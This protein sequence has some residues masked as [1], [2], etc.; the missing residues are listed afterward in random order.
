M[1]G[2][3]FGRALAD[4]VL[5]AG[6]VPRVYD[7]FCTPPAALAAGSSRALV[8]SSDVVVLAVP[9]A[10]VAT[11]LAE[12]RPHL[13]HPT[14]VMDVASVKLG[15]EAALRAALGRD[16]RWVATHPL[17]GPSSL[18]R[19][20]RP[21]RAVVCP[22]PDHPEAVR[23]AR[24]LYERLGCEVVET[25]ADAHDRIM[26]RT[27]ALAFFVAKAMV[28]VEGGEPVP[29]SPPSFR[30]MAR[31]I[32]TVRSDA[33]HL[34]FAIQHENAHAAAERRRFI[35]ALEAIDHELGHTDV[36]APEH[37]ESRLA[38]PDLEA[39]APELRHI[40]ELIAE[41]DRELV[42]LVAR[43]VRLSRRAASAGLADRETDDRER[44]SADR[45]AWATARGLDPGVI[46][47]I[48]ESIAR[49]V[50]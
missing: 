11:A 29:F 46:S 37:V 23:R 1:G 26:A 25:D 24:D 47:E 28:E 38:I 50:D 9:V 15:P 3:R 5:E 16:I 19:G 7:P 42:E 6:H 27:H 2:G 35:D 36:A 31:T 17:F 45:E 33:G 13:R 22:N 18:A 34:F 14:W 43:R 4:L 10:A 44:T 40:G 49:H 20:E 48:F 41:I 8:E 21:L 12:I 30:A 32:E 39:P